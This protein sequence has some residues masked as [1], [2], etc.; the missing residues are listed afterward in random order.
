MKSKLF[1]LLIP[2][3]CLF[4]CDYEPVHSPNNSKWVE[5]TP[6]LTNGNYSM[7]GLYVYEDKERGYIVYS[8]DKGLCAV[9]IQHPVA[10]AK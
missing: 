5:I 9:P 2:T 4:G 3:A 8:N 6:Y 7:N 1:L 10:E